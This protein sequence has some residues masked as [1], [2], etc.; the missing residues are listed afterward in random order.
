MAPAIAVQAADTI[1]RKVT[2]Q[3]GVDGNQQ[4]AKRDGGIA[5]PQPTQQNKP[6][7]GKRKA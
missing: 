5:L 7:G 3:H 6:A 2:P 1:G 4:G